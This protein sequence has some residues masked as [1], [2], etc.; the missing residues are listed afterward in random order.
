MRRPSATGLVFCL[1]YAAVIVGCR[2]MASNLQ[3]DGHLQAG[4]RQ[5]PFV[6]ITLPLAMLDLLPWLE[7]LPRVVAYALVLL[8]MFWASYWLGRSLER[9]IGGVVASRRAASAR[10]HADGG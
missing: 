1:L 7:R 6:P 4:L 3:V 5:L 2:W 9:W 8:P 10:R